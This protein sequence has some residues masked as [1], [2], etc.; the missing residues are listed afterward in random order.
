MALVPDQ[1]CRES[2]T[3]PEIERR[4]DLGGWGYGGGTEGEVGDGV[5]GEVAGVYCAV[6][7]Y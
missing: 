6:A 2:H 5:E 7:C 1:T 3:H 4:T